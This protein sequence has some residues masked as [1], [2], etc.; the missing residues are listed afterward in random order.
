MSFSKMIQNFKNLFYQKLM[1][2]EKVNKI[3]VI[4]KKLK[5]IILMHV[6]NASLRL[7][8]MMKT[9]NT[10]FSYAEMLKIRSNL[11]IKT[12]FKQIEWEITI[13]WHKC[14]FLDEKEIVTEL[15]ELREVMWHV[16]YK[17]SKSWK[18]MTLVSSMLS[19]AHVEACWAWYI[20]N[21]LRDI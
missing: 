6:L 20:E 14:L 15:I 18:C 4:W 19:M 13:L 10:A 1:K 7:T 9:Q 17:R 12:V 2:I 5:H 11:I 21:V 16:E 8:T 3:F